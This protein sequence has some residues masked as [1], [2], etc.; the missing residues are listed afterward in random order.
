LKQRVWGD[1]RFKIE[2]RVSFYFWLNVSAIL[3]NEKLKKLSEE[4]RKVNENADDLHF[5]NFQEFDDSVLEND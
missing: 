4:R 1:F 5:E 3:C 2:G